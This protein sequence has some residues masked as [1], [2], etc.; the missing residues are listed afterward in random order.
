MSLQQWAQIPSG[1]GMGVE[2]LGELSG[3]LEPQR[4]SA[5]SVSPE[6]CDRKT[7]CQ[8]AAGYPCELPGTEGCEDQKG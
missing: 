3:G 1:V 5:I 4:R 8:E 2:A 6:G 7:S